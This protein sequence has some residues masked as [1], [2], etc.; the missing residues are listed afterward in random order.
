MHSSACH[1]LRPQTEETYL[2]GELLARDLQD[3]HKNNTTS[4]RKKYARNH[5]PVTPAYTLPLS[6]KS[7]CSSTNL[8]IKRN[9][10]VLP[11]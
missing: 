8:L 10:H 7:G 4:I 2:P 11:A 3:S 6:N 1:S 5:L 9:Q